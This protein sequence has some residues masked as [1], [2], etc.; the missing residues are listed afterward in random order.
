MFLRRKQLLKILHFIDALDDDLD[1][2]YIISSYILLTYE[3][4]QRNKHYNDEWFFSLFIMRISTFCN[5]LI[6]D[7]TIAT[8]LHIKDFFC[9][10]ATRR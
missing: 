5:V 4:F 1:K 7:A 2:K 9:N 3:I 8:L 6:Q 10:T